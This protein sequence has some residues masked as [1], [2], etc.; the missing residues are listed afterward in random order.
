[1][2]AKTFELCPFEMPTIREILGYKSKIGEA[3]R[4]HLVKSYQRMSMFLFFSIARVRNSGIFSMWA[5]V[6]ASVSYGT[7]QGATA[8]YASVFFGHACTRKTMHIL[9]QP[10]R[11]ETQFRERVQARLDREVVN[12]NKDQGLSSSVVVLILIFDNAQKNYA[13]K[14]QQGGN[15]SNYIKVTAR[16]VFH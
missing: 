16:C 8:R 4:K 14:F 10:Y 11:E 3:R 9:T 7:V 5:L 6:G 2:Q 1:M 13:Y 15:T 12:I